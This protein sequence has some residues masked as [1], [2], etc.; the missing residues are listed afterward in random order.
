[1]AVI[2]GMDLGY[3]S[4]VQLVKTNYLIAGVAV[5]GTATAMANVLNMYNDAVE[6]SIKADYIVCV[7]DNGTGAGTAQA[8]TSGT[9][10]TVIDSSTLTNWPVRGPSASHLA[11]AAGLPAEANSVADIGTAANGMV[12]GVLS[13]AMMDFGAGFAAG[14]HIVTTLGSERRS[15]AELVNGRL[16]VSNVAGPTSHINVTD[17]VADLLEAATLNGVATL[18]LTNA[19]FTTDYVQKGNTAGTAAT[20]FGAA[21]ATTVVADTCALLSVVSLVRNA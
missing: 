17:V 21:A 4:Q 3:G 11:Q 7:N 6:S 16:S 13:V 2:A 5:N 8:P 1:M 14:A 9:D 19:A 10:P 20:A 18:D 12:L 15:L